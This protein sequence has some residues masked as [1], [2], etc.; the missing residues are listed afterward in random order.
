MC[1]GAIISD[2]ILPAR[3]RR[4]SADHLWPDL[5]KKKK[6]GNRR[7]PV[8][9]CAEEFE[10]DFEADFEEFTDETD[11][12]EIVEFEQFAFRSKP[13]PFA[14][15]DASFLKPVHVTGPIDQS[16]KRKRKNQYRG[17][18]QRPWGKWAAEIRDPKKGERV[19]LGTF[20]TP[21][22]AA[23]A[24]DAAARKIRGKKAKVNFAEETLKA[25]QNQHLKL[26]LQDAMKENSMEEHSFN[27]FGLL[28]GAHYAFYSNLG[29]GDELAPRK[30]PKQLNS[31]KAL[32][33]FSP[34]EEG[35]NL[36][37]EQESNSFNC[38]GYGWEHEF[39]SPEI[40]SVPLVF[41]DR[42]S[43]SLEEKPPL[44]K[45]KSNSCNT[46]LID[47]EAGL[48][49][50]DEVTDFEQFMK[51]VPF[52]EVSSDGS[53]DSLG[54]EMTQEGTNFMD[55]WCFDDMPMSGFEAGMPFL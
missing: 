20:D 17:I 45:P 31:H 7:F 47:Q 12:E 48:K 39:K 24:Y 15:E 53:F 14:G 44:K 9:T 10:E 54:T 4:A 49:L 40:S 11:E 41:E 42:K 28:N 30:P 8:M 2:L 3:L 36:H 50:S 18:R 52:I 34:L 43:Q 25:G 27:S 51:L 23:K 26:T 55:L 13:A 46:V 35:I 29:L 5:V 16:A 6:K 38:S 1:G 33:P 32:N 21:V 19:W 22:E 37:S